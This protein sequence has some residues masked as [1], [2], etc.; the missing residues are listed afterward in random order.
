MVNKMIRLIFI[1]LILSTSLLFPQEFTGQNTPSDNSKYYEGKNGID[2]NL[3]F[4]DNSNVTTSSVVTILNSSKVSNATGG[5]SGSISYQYWFKNYLSVRI[6]I[7]TLVT[8]VE[9]KTYTDL[10]PFYNYSGYVTTEVATISSILT[11][12]NFYP[13]QISDEKR[14]LP[15]VS[16][17]AGPYI[18]VYNRSE[19]QNTSVVEETT[20]QTA[21]G[22]RTGA[23][24]S[25]LIGSIFKLGV[26]FGYN[27]IG[28][29]D[30]P[31]AAK[32]NYSGPDYSML[33]G[34]VF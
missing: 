1:P 7:G 9:N 30:N 20:V 4:Y 26:D 12:L 24:F 11:G 6:G 29:F 8:N 14:F 16:F 10:D 18:G 3:G 22:C 28:D 5:F 21:F 25:V 13:L 31:I 34:F 33:F 2:L 17:Y 15:Y 19:V 23:G 32:D 27:F